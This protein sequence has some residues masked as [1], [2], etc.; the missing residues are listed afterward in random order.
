MTQCEHKSYD[1]PLHMH[2]F[3]MFCVSRF[4]IMKDCW[5]ENPEDRPN[6]AE[7][8]VKISSLIESMSDYMEVMTFI[9]S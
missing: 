3:S 7:I 2:Y 6:F 8:R 1:H 9:G 4:A 5:F